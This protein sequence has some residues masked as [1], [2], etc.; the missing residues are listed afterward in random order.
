MNATAPADFMTPAERLAAA[1]AELAEA[2]EEAKAE[3][4]RMH[5]AGASEYTIANEL[6]VART[7][8]RTWLRRP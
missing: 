5:A 7:T 6:G 2:T 8:V 3:S 4:R 1:R